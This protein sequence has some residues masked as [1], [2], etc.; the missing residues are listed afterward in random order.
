ME[1]KFSKKLTGF[2]KSQNT[3]YS[4]LRMIESW[5]SQLHNGIKIGTIIWIY[6]KSLIVWTIILLNK[7]ATYGLGNNSLEFFCIYI[8]DR[9]Q[10]CKINNSFSQWKRFLA[11]VLQGSIFGLFLFNIFINDIFIFLKTLSSQIKLMI[12]IYTYVRKI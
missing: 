10:R 4:L 8:S 1:S 6:Q 9:Y 7:F 5:K 3:H 12:V 2:R 11:D